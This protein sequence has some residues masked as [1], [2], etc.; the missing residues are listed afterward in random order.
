[1][2]ASIAQASDG[3]DGLVNATP[4]GMAGYGGSAFPKTVLNGPR[5]AF[6]AVYTPIDTPF[7]LSACAA[8]L[9]V[10]SGY[11]LFFHQ[12]VDAFAIFTGRQVDAKALRQAI[13]GKRA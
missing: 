9:S 8:G 6:D 1:V 13:E 11:E 3:A 5:W 2:C 10:I 4:L 7:V 12:G